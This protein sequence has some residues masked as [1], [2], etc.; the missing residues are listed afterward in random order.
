MNKKPRKNHILYNLPLPEDI[1]NHILFF[2]NYV[3]VEGELIKINKISKTLP[4]Y[5]LLSDIIKNLEWITCFENWT[6]L[7]VTKSIKDHENNSIFLRIKMYIDPEK[8]DKV[9]YDYSN[10]TYIRH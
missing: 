4:I 2:D 1:V 8:K 6:I 5:K 10:K 7:R 9:Y 3:I